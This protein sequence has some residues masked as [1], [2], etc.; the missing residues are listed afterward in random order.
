MKK[1]IQNNRGASML[2]VLA[3]LIV[4]GFIGVA[5][6]KTT[7]SDKVGNVLYRS[8]ESARSAAK[9]GMIAGL[10]FFEQS[11]TATITTQ[12]IPLLQDW[13]DKPLKSSIPATHK[14][15][16]GDASSYETI[17]GSVLKYRVELLAF[18]SKKFNITL[19]SE[20]I[21][22]GGSKA[23]ITGVYHLD[24]LMFKIT[25]TVKPTTALYLGGG[26]G[27]LD[28]A[29]N[30]HGDMYLR[31]AGECYSS[32]P[33]QRFNFYGKTYIDSGNGKFLVKK[34]TFH[35]EVYFSGDTQQLQLVD[36]L[37][38]EFEKS[39]GIEHRLEIGSGVKANIDGNLY[40]NGTIGKLSGAGNI[41]SSLIF[42][43]TTDKVRYSSD[44][45]SQYIKGTTD[46]SKVST[47]DIP[48]KL[49][50][51]KP[52]KLPINKNIWA[53]KEIT[54]VSGWHGYDGAKMNEIYKHNCIDADNC[55]ETNNGDKWLVIK[56]TKP[57]GQPFKIGGTG[58]TGK[59]IWI[60]DGGRK[61]SATQT[62]Y[63][64]SVSV[65]DSSDTEV[66]TTGG[67]S[68]FYIGPTSSI[69]RVGG[70]ET[71]RGFF[72]SESD[73]KDI[74]TAKK[75]GIF[76]GGVYKCSDTGKFRLEGAVGVTNTGSF[77]IFYDKGVVDDLEELGIFSDPTNDI[78][79]LELQPTTTRLAT[80]LVSQAM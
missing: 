64:H 29:M 62:M 35:Q 18:D 16:K 45:I 76:Y 69:Y 70:M 1:V 9:S 50:I 6:L 72:Y 67:I 66:K 48:A 27:E 30:I 78:K 25:N 32:D 15:I 23:T 8:S 28:R 5:M 65:V 31:G 11:G 19:R 55:L 20:G 41:D 75:D 22:K 61:I 52:P 59:V 57:N 74:F 7:T 71:F 2:Y 60:V 49:G 40:C 17:D 37:Q 26:A 21:G 44:D 3:A 42:K 39:V 56:Y 13:V 38:P 47:M 58:F 12:I 43:A 33:S 79:I 10:S 24:G 80:Q 46:I 4:T 34:S 14:W 68:V 54:L 51:V 73:Q 63:E 53:G 36:T 77:D